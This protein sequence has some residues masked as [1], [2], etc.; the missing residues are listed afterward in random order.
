MLAQ[1][2]SK[3]LRYNPAKPFDLGTKHTDHLPS[4]SDLLKPGTDY[5]DRK[6]IAAIGTGLC[7]DGNYSGQRHSINQGYDV[8]IGQFMGATMGNKAPSIKQAFT[9]LAA[10]RGLETVQGITSVGASQ[11]IIANR[12]VRIPGWLAARWQRQEQLRLKPQ[13][14]EQNEFSDQDILQRQSA[15]SL[16]N[17]LIIQQD[18]QGNT[19]E[20]V[21]IGPPV[22]SSGSNGTFHHISELCKVQSMGASNMTRLVVFNIRVHERAGFIV[23]VDRMEEI[24]NVTLSPDGSQ[25][26][27]IESEMFYDEQGNQKGGELIVGWYS[28]RAEDCPP[29]DNY[30]G[31]DVRKMFSD[32]ANEEGMGH[33][34]DNSRRTQQ[35]HQSPQNPPSNQ[36]PY[37]GQQPFG[38]PPA[39]GQPYGS[40]GGQQ[41]FGD[42]PYQSGQK[43]FGGYNSGGQQPFGNP[44][45]YQAPRQRR[46]APSNSTP[47]SE[48]PSN[49]GF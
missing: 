34:V 41:P 35:Q 26:R 10:G 49:S 29:V 32:F 30:Q 33:I 15:I 23:S 39:Q 38:N 45:S 28:D 22:M 18:S 17:S 5:S 2:N 36:Y 21:R 40:Y 13:C 47:Y 44:P 48:Q 27:V 19:W 6:L 3:P 46:F 11:G 43:P 14:F 20:L 4:L 1:T 25:I 9:D 31:L 8:N 12:W 7:P 16:S 42:P 37:G 24:Q